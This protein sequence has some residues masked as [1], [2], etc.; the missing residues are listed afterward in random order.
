METSVVPVCKTGQFGFWPMHSV[1]VYSTEPCSAKPDV[2]ISE[3]RGFRISRIS[4]E[5]SKMTTADP[6]DWRT[7]LVRYLENPSHIADRKVLHQALKYVMLDN[8]LYRQT[9]DGFLLKCL[10]SDQSKIA[11]REVHQ[12]YSGSH[13]SAHKMKWLLCRA[14]F[15]WPT[16]ISYCFR[17]YKGCESC[18]KFRDVQLA[19]AV[20]P[21]S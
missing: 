14:E 2:P 13:Q 16:R 18:Q 5:S 11:M 3:T 1:T 10:G 9:I 19:F 4:D 12:G 21:P 7:P 17:Y 8:T 6:D 15:S 20:T